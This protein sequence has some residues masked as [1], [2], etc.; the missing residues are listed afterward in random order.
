[1]HFLAFDVEYS[2]PDCE[3]DGVAIGELGENEVAVDA[4]DWSNDSHVI[5]RLCG[6]KKMMAPVISSGN[7]VGK[8]IYE[9]TNLVLN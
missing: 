6:R 7:K 5:R 4:F 9:F 3:F 8:K 2:G 1:M